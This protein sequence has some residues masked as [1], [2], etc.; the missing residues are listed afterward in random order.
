MDVPIYLK[1]LGSQAGIKLFDWD[2]STQIYEYDFT[3]NGIGVD[4]RL[5]AGGMA[6]GIAAIGPNF[7]AVGIHTGTVVVFEVASDED[8]F[9]CRVAD[10]Q[11]SHWHPITDL[12]S[13]TVSSA[14]S[15]GAGA[16]AA[17]KDMM[18][19][20][21]ETGLL[22][23]W[24][25]GATAASDGITR[26]AKIDSHLSDGAV[27]AMALW[28]RIGQGV[29]VAGYG[30]GLLRVFSLPTGYVVAEVAAH[31]GWVTGMDLA[32]QSGLL[33]TCS[34]DGF[35]RVGRITDFL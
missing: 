27:T 23:V 15:S 17:T 30:S 10:S 3:E 14:S 20:A 32:S 6:R 21:D 5:V 33:V 8:G 31:A 12:A 2:G 26:K 34:E 22:N 29:A 18:V 16:S 9:V 25:L 28:N 13:T 35:V 1:L 11:R 19:S 24:S 4:D 7:I